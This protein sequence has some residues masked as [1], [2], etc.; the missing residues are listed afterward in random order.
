MPD[1]ICS[2]NTELRLTKD[3]VICSFSTLCFISSASLCRVHGEGGGWV[4]PA[5]DLMTCGKHLKADRR[6]FI[7]VYCDMICNDRNKFPKFGSRV[8]LNPTFV[9]LF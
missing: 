5:M 6:G 3:D 4:D 8:L 9:G 7:S 1:L 2:V